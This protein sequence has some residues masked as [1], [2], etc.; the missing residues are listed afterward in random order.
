MCANFKHSNTCV[1]ELATLQVNS[2]GFVS[3]LGS[4]ACAVELDH[5][6]ALDN[7]INTFSFSFLDHL[8]SISIFTDLITCS[9]TWY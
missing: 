7:R 1:R 5:L 3:S 6:M 8:M 2:Q 9:I 4:N